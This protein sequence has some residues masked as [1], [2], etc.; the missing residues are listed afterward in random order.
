[1]LN[2]CLFLATSVALITGISSLKVSAQKGGRVPGKAFHIHNFS[3]FERK[4]EPLTISR[5]E[6]EKVLKTNFHINRYVVIRDEDGKELP[7][8]MDDLDGDG[9]WDEVALLIDVDLGDKTKLYLEKVDGK[10]RY[11]KKTQAWL[12]VSPNRDNLFSPVTKETMPYNWKA[13]SQPMRY[14]LEGPGWENDKVGFRHY[15]DSRNGKDIFGKKTTELTLHKIGIPNTDLGDYHK[16]A[17]WGMDV[18]KVGNTLGAGG[19]AFLEGDKLVPVGNGRE[20][21]YEVVCEGPVRAIIKITHIGVPFGKRAI[22]LVE[23]ITIWKGK[24]WFK[25]EVSV[26]GVGTEDGMDLAI[27]FTNLKFEGKASQI[28]EFDNYVGLATH[29]K[30]SENGDILGMAIVLPKAQFKGFSETPKTGEGI[31]SSYYGKAFTRLAKPI[32]YYFFAAWEKSNPKFS[33]N[34]YF[35]ESVKMEMDEFD[36]PL[37]LRK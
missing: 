24:Y 31:V 19:F 13:Q 8:Q 15:F 16:E 6:L 17:E 33:A 5:T 27:G 23:N 7:S 12:G 30:Q 35:L 10:P 25:N 37:E 32:T 1:M 21:L 36:E 28:D 4:D 20:K 3:E 9:I 11:P 29:G 2:K 14:Q 18:L 34:N 26:A 22:T